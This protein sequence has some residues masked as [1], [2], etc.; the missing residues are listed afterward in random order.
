MFISTTNFVYK[1][2]NIF[3]FDV[4]ESLLMSKGKYSVVIY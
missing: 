2:E 4:M 3:K 1:I